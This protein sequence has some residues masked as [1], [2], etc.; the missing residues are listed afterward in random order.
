MVKKK[1]FDSN[2]IQKGNVTLLQQFLKDYFA[3]DV[4]RNVD[5]QRH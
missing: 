1:Y 2:I 5:T 4:N 3:A